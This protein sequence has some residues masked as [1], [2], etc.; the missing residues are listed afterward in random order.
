MKY[1]GTTDRGKLRKSNQDNYVIA[2][3]RN[4][5]VFAIVCDGIGGGRGGDI[6][7][8]MTV[9][10]FSELFAEHA[11]FESASDAKYWLRINISEINRRI[12][13]RS[14]DQEELR[15]MGTT[16]CG[17]LK[18]SVGTF[19]VNIGDSRAYSWQKDTGLKQL[20]IDH[21]LVQDM[22][23]HGEITRK[24]AENYPRKNVLT[25]ALGVW[26]SVRS[27][28][29]THPEPVQ[30]YL[31]CSDGLHGYVDEKSIAKIVMTKGR[32]PALKVRRLI[33]AALDAGGFDNITVILIDLEGE[34]AV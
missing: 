23:M 33:K 26:E 24:E 4:G 22:I 28:I 10:Y 14:K 29:D 19:V 1:C 18:A 6:A 7:S 27:D 9:N 11:G 13:Q 3:N 17:V 5:D 30:G 32:D 34:N 15:G 21:T 20:T 31:I 2:T 16:M 8:R 12:F 25:N